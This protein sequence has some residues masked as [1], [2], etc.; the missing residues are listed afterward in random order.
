LRQLSESGAL[1]GRTREGR[2]R[3]AKAAWLRS[4][5]NRHVRILSAIRLKQET[6]IN[7]AELVV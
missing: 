7:R 2:N 1:D 6:G 3:R 5:H 4:Y